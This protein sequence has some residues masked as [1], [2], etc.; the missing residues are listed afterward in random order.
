MTALRQSIF[1]YYASRS[2][3]TEKDP[4]RRIDS[5]RI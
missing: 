5:G 3:Q 4:P 2:L 1:I